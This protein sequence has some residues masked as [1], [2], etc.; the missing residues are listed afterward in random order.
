MPEKALQSLEGWQAES[1]RLTAFPSPA[2]APTTDWWVELLRE[3]PEQ[4]TSR[5][6]GVVRREEGDFK[7]GR[8]V[9]EVQSM[10]VDWHYALSQQ[11]HLEA[12]GFGTLGP[13]PAALEPF[14]DLM[15]RWL[16]IA[17]PLQRL[18]FGVALIL[19]TEDLAASYQQLAAYLPFRVD[20]E[21]ASDFL[22]QINRPRRRP[23]FLA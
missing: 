17:P 10:R 20:T 9:L 7:E 11:A 4:K 22:Y 3:P 2:A 14:Q 15:L 18:A 8:L 6:K 1:F 21:G 5:L 12:E 16:E 19:P 23:R 13:F